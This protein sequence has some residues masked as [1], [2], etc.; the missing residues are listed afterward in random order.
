MPP[1][2][3]IPEDEAAADTVF[4]PPVDADQAYRGL[5]SRCSETTSISSTR[6]PYAPM[7]N[8]GN[9]VPDRQCAASISLDVPASDNPHTGL[10]VRE[11]EVDSPHAGHTPEVPLYGR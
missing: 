3:S 6:P 7:G 1:R 5:G 11:G 8:F 2:N 10:A 4:P 9:P